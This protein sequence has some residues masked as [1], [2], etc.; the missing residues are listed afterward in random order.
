VGY[1]AVG[2]DNAP[3]TDG[4]TLRNEYS[5]TN[6]RTPAYFDG[7]DVVG[8]RQAICDSRVQR[9]RMTV[10][11]RNLAVAGDQDIVFDD[12]LAIA[13]NG[14][15]V[16]DKSP[17]AYAQNGTVAESSRGH[18]EAPAKPDIIANIKQRV[19]ADGGQTPQLQTL[20]NGFAPAA[21][22]RR[23]VD[24][25]FNSG[26][27]RRNVKSQFVEQSPGWL[28]RLRHRYGR[29]ETKFQGFATSS[30]ER[31]VPTF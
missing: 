19:P 26:P 18:R 8:A 20:S 23:S 2:P 13:S 9:S 17:A 15:I 12:H 16:S 5:S 1:D 4:D 30:K 27:Q 6:P 25:R 11:I 3:L 29:G 24:Q 22:Y 14:H 7:P 31:T 10:V 21:E 28:Q